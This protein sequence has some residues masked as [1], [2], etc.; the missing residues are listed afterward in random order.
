MNKLSLS[1]L[2]LLA[3]GAMAMTACSTG[4]KTSEDTTANASD[5]NEMSAPKDS[6]AI[7]FSDPAK[8][9]EVATDSTYAETP[10]GLKYMILKEG[11][12]KSP[13]ATDVVEVH[14]EGK[15]TDGFVFDSSMQRGEPAAFPLNRVIPGWTEGLQLMKEGGTAVFYIPAAIGYGSAGSPPVIPP[16]ADLIFTVQLLK[17][18]D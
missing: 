11:E 13:K 4:A 1:A 12:G 8:K 15:L 18:Q 6:L 14:Y 10:S 7:I 9:S 5:I 17:V 2:S 16:N 3:A